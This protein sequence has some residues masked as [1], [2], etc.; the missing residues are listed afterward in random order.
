MDDDFL[1][2]MDASGKIVLPKQLRTGLPAE[3]TFSVQRADDTIVLKLHVPDERTS[4]PETTLSEQ[5]TLPAELMD[6]SGI[7]HILN[8]LAACERHYGLTSDEFYQRYTSGELV[9]DGYLAYWATCYQTLHTPGLAT[10]AAWLDALDAIAETANTIDF[11]DTL[12]VVQEAIEALELD[13][14]HTGLLLAERI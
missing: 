14:L 1:V 4:V 8:Y 5:I 12:P 9:R 3:T 7:R 6:R 2:Q 11:G 13:P 10:D